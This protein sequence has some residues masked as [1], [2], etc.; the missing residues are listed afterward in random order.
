MEIRKPTMISREEWDAQEPRDYIDDSPLNNVNNLI[1]H[2]TDTPNE[3]VGNAAYRRVKNIQNYHRNAT[4][5]WKAEVWAD[6]GYH[7]LISHDG[8]IFEGRNTKYMGAH[9]LNENHTSI[10]ISLIGTFN[11][12]YI[13]QAQEKSLIHLLAWLKEKYKLSIHNIKGHKDFNST[14]CPGDKVYTNLSE[15]KEKV[16]DILEHNFISPVKTFTTYYRVVSGSFKNRGNAI[17]QKAKL[18][19]LGY[20]PFLVYENSYYRVIVGSFKLKDNALSLKNTLKKKEIDSFL[21]LY[22]KN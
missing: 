13:S 7:Y 14:D 10:G 16:T 17:E 5:S 22:N 9:T 1:I 6:I 8:L 15:I 21:L 3:E 20:D 4:N 19:T 11:E 18:A 12:T 2:H